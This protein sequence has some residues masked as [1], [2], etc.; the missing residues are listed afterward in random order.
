M[1][2]LSEKINSFIAAS[3]AARTTLSE[4]SGLALKSIDIQ[5]A[6]YE[7]LN[8]SP[9]NHWELLDR[10]FTSSQILDHLKVFNFK[11]LKPELL[12]EIV[13]E[14]P[15]LPENI[16]RNLN[17][18]TIKIKGEVWRI[19]KNDVDPF[20]SSPHAHNYESGIVLHLGTGEMFSSANKKSV[21]SIGC[22]K[23][24]RLRGEL[25]AFTLPTTECA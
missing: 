25:G 16:P 5:T 11:K 1:D 24:M 4:K 10:R 21:G 12:A 13:L 2:E 20:P 6:L 9:A 22:K 3:E 7:V 15:I 19:H 14:E 8:I 18:E 17:E 23:L